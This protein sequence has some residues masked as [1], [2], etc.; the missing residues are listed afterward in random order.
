MDRRSLHKAWR[1]LVVLRASCDVYLLLVFML[2]ERISM[3]PQMVQEPEIFI[4]IF[5][6]SLVAFQVLGYSSQSTG[7]VKVQV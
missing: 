4:G 5:T 6:A 1:K 2:L 3:D 7:Y